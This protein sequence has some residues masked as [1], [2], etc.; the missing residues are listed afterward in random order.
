MS[1]ATP[2]APAGTA[3]DPLA[4]TSPPMLSVPEPF[5]EIAAPPAPPHP[6]WSRAPTA[7]VHRWLLT[8][9]FAAAPSVGEAPVV[10]TRANWSCRLRVAVI[11]NRLPCGQ[12]AQA[13]W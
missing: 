13:T 12:L 2:T 10:S 8:S 3:I 7:G 1:P 9:L 4:T 6:A 5:T 11:V